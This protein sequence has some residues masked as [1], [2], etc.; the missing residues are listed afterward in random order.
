M[1]GKKST[2]RYI[3]EAIGGMLI[4]AALIGYMAL[5]G[6][7]RATP[8]VVFLTALI[9]IAGYA[10]LSFI[11]SRRT[12]RVFWTLYAI[13]IA[14]LVLPCPLLLLISQIMWK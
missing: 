12:G 4:P 10:V 6:S 5:V 8:D 11:A 9:S 13:K 3:A 7:Y 14:L 2:G 1:N